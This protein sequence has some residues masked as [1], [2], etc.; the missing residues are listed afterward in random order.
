MMLRNLMLNDFCYDDAVAGHVSVK[1]ACEACDRRFGAR[2]P[3]A[4]SRGARSQ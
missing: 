1:V 3:A 4:I 2:I